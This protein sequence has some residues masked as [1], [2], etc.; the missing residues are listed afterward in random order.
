[1]LGT[2]IK[3]NGGSENDINKFQNN[4]AGA[5]SYPLLPIYVSF[6]FIH[7]VGQYTLKA[8]D[9]LILICDIVLEMT[10]QL[11]YHISKCVWNTLYDMIHY[12]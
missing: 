11:I 7:D 5:M 1:M 3:N 6:K 8:R 4:I 12:L 2:V 10:T 9:E